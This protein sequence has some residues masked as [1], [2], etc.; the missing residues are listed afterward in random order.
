MRKNPK[1]IFQNP[2]GST[3]AERLREDFHLAFLAGRNACPT[4]FDRV[5][6]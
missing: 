3:L 6:Q 1:K 2:H 4:C 5:S